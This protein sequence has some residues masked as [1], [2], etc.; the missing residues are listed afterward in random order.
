MEMMDW[1][2]DVLKKLIKIEEELGEKT[3]ITMDYTVYLKRLLKLIEDASLEK[4]GKKWNAWL[5]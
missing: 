5:T 2:A 3:T 4:R 1:K